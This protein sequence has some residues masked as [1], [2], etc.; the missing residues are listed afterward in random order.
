MRI[1]VIPWYRTWLN[2]HAIA[3]RYSI[4]SEEKWPLNRVEWEGRRR[5]KVEKE[6]G[7]GKRNKEREKLLKR[8]EKEKKQEKRVKKTKKRV[9]H[10][11][12]NQTLKFCTCYQIEVR[13]HDNIANVSAYWVL[14][15][16]QS[17]V[18]HGMHGETKEKKRKTGKKTR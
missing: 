6:E 10:C 2:I 13:R 9:N 17:L 1:A 8:K 18:W 5:R 14:I 7:E 4:E 12:N 16:A 15:E 3:A 11:Q